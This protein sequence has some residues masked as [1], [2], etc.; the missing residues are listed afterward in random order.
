[1]SKT[2]SG[3]WRRRCGCRGRSVAGQNNDLDLAVIKNHGTIAVYGNNG[4]NKFTVDVYKTFWRNVRY[5]FVLLYP[6]SPTCVALR[7][8]T[9]T[10]QRRPAGSGSARRLAC[11]FTTSRWRSSEQPTMRSRVVRSARC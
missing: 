5:Q 3:Q 4:G 7:A 6:L 10:P 11:P 2:R 8:R 1:M 9:S